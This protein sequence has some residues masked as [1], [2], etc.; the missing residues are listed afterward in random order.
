MSPASEGQGWNTIVFICAI[1]T[2][3]AGSSMTSIGCLRP[4]GKVTSVSRIHSGTPFGGFF[5]KYCSP[6]T[7]SG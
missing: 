3:A 1:Q 5:E 2:A 6:S 7:P 4:L